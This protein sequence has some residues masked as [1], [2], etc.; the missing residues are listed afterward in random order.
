[1]HEAELLRARQWGKSRRVTSALLD[2]LSSPAVKARWVRQQRHW[3]WRLWWWLRARV[4]D[5]MANARKW[6]TWRAR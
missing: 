2:A 5:R 4:A 3:Y 6:A 1:M